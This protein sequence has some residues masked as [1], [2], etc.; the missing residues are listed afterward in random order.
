[1]RAR[2]SPIQ[3][4]PAAALALL[5]TGLSST[6]AETR[7]VALA[8][9]DAKSAFVPDLRADEVRV[10]E[11][12]AACEITSFEKDERPLSVALVLDTSD[13]AR[14][15]FGGLAI[16]T[17]QSCLAHLPPGARCALWTTGDRARKMGELKGEMAAIEKKVA[18]GFG[19]GGSNALLETLVEAAAGLGGESGRRRALVAVT[20]RASGHTSWG[21]GDVTSR[22]RRADARVFGV[23]Y[24][25]G[26]PGQTGSLM[27]LD[28]PRDAANLTVVG[29]ADHE[30]ILNGLA[31][32]T[33]GRF[34]SVGTATAVSRLLEAYAAELVGQYRV[35]FTVV[36]AKG[37]KRIEARVARPGLRWRVAVDSP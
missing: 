4:A 30:R 27:G 6:A 24:R 5:A 35:R 15:V 3:L 36:E 10:L 12:G 25:E 7:T 14:R 32:G 21:P 18:R 9:T 37:P 17:V 26:S 11:N 23:I 8:V 34:E 16:P 1:M 29:E 13:E 31:Q 20:G 22:V 28:A 19:S 33:G 2:L